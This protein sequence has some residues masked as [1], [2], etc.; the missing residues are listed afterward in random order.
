MSGKSMCD[1]Q[2]SVAC[3]TIILPKYMGGSLPTGLP[4][5]PLMSVAVTT[6][7]PPHFQALLRPAGST[8]TSAYNEVVEQSGASMYIETAGS[9]LVDNGQDRVPCIL[10]LPADVGV[11]VVRVGDRVSSMGALVVR[12]VTRVR[13]EG[14]PDAIKIQG[15]SSYR[16]QDDKSRMLNL[17]DARVSSRLEIFSCMVTCL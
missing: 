8:G 11:L 14:S 3:S 4:C 6:V 10:P 15:T 17:S 2:N 13:Y 1:H 16:S 12:P 7:L 9:I 5:T